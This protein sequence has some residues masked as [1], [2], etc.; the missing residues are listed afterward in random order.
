LIYRLEERGSKVVK[1]APSALPAAVELLS[2]L[3]SYLPQR[4]PSLFQSTNNETGKGM[5]NLV[6]GE[7]FTVD[8]DGC[9]RNGVKEDPMSLCARMVQDDLAIMV[10]GGDGMY[11]FLA[12]AILL[13]GFWRLQDKFGMGLSEIHTSGDVPGFVYLAPPISP[14][15]FSFSSSPPHI[16]ELLKGDVKWC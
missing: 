10:E 7:V 16:S 13:A 5:R 3:T 9:E 6:T 2:E 1:T 11:Y 14:D 15:I 8:G 12:G 4:Y